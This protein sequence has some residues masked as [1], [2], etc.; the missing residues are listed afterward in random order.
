MQTSLLKVQQAINL[1]RLSLSII[2]I[3]CQVDLFI[4]LAVYL[5]TS[6]TVNVLKIL[7]GLL[8][9]FCTAYKYL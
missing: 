1:F 9:V 6:D 8:L 2:T 4:S 7:F 3:K 5:H